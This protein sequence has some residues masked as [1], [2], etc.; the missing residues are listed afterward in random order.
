MPSAQ[1]SVAPSPTPGRAAVALS[2]DLLKILRCPVSGSTLRQ[3]GDQL[4]S[5]DDPSLRYAIERGVPTLLA[6]R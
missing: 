3:D 2:D 6:P 1:S 4:I 5:T